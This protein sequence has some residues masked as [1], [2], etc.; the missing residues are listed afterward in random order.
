LTI[1]V[2]AVPESQVV[3]AKPLPQAKAEAEAIV[4][5]L[6]LLPGVKVEMLEI[7]RL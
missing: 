3:P 2:I 1:V 7:L 5:A 6:S 4:Q